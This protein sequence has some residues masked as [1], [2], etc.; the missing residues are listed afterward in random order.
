MG[1]CD[2]CG[3]EARTGARFCANCGADLPLS[4]AGSPSSPPPIPARPEPTPKGRSVL[5]PALGIA[6]LDA[7]GLGI[8]HFLVRRFV[9]GIALLFG[10][11]VVIGSS[12][13]LPNAA[14]PFLIAAWLAVSGLI[15]YRAARKTEVTT[16]PRL[17]TGAGIAAIAAILAG[18]LLYAHASANAYAAGLSA[19]RKGDCKKAID[20]YDQVHGMYALSFHSFSGADREKNECRDL[21]A[22]DDML[23]RAYFKRAAD[24]YASFRSEHP[25]AVIGQDALAARRAHAQSRWAARQIELTR[26]S[27]DPAHLAAAAEH[28]D[29]ALVFVPAYP[30]A[31]KGFATVNHLASSGDLCARAAL[32]RRPRR[33]ALPLASRGGA[34]WPL[35]QKGTGPH[36][37][38]RGEAACARP[39]RT[40]RHSAF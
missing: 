4:D 11:F 6:L 38:L 1:Y 32:Q 34:S 14:A 2:R 36:A 7:S 18:Y 24:R 33:R 25:G 31:S 27:A 3:T 5:T 10:T 17:S 40:G 8:G 39:F 13:G 16:N 37:R 29:R 35:A 23:D 21:L 28:Y 22:I 15:G 26:S 30:A 9:G 19:H 20:S 12:I